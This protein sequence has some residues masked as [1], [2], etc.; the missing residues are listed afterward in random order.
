[1]DIFERI[2][3]LN[4]KGIIVDCV[5]VSQIDN[6][7]EEGVKNREFPLMTYTVEVMDESLGE[8]FYTESCDSFKEA[9]YVGV[10]FAEQMNK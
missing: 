2:Q 7:N 1:M 8:I 4:K 3:E 6:G 9:I 5:A 10:K